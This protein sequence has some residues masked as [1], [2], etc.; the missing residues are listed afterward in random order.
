MIPLFFT[1]NRPPDLPPFEPA[2]I[3]NSVSFP[4]NGGISR[5]ILSLGVEKIRVDSQPIWTMIRDSKDAIL[6]DGDWYAL[7]EFNIITPINV[8]DFERSDSIL[9]S[10][11][12]A[13]NREG[14]VRVN[15][16][17]AAGGGI[18][19]PIRPEL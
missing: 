3:P 18:F 6:R 4:G 19:E 16:T 7:I 17:Q 12:T 11:R 13:D 15:V 2:V 5:H 9:L 14:V 8:F 10:C 1:L